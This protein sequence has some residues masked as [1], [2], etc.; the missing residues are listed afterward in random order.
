[1]ITQIGHISLNI[2]LLIYL[3]YFIPQLIHNYR[4]Q[5]TDEISLQTQ[6]LMLTASASGMVY[7]FGFNL[8][9]QYNLVSVVSLLSLVIQ[10]V[11]IT[12][13]NRTRR[14]SGAH[15]STV[16]LVG[17]SVFY[18]IMPPA[19]HASLLILGYI[20]NLLYAY[21]W[22]PQVI[23]NYRTHQ[24]DG[25]S[26]LFLLLVNFSAL[27]DLVSALALYWPLPSIISP[28]IIMLLISIQILQKLTYRSPRQT[29]VA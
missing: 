6:I 18:S 29:V 24:T 27:C 25:F 12:W 21:F 5:H 15:I 10:H 3:V 7:G 28:I 4:G 16:A 14:L 17:L 9:W 2:S 1:M 22:L 23:Y 11:Q 26:M 20:S 8:E 19:N 13:Y